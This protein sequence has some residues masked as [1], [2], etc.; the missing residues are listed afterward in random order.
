MSAYSDV[1]SFYFSSEIGVETGRVKVYLGSLAALTLKVMDSSAV[2]V[3]S[4]MITY[5]GEG[6]CTVIDN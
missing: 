2:A 5:V 3:S 6:L 1:D 4:A